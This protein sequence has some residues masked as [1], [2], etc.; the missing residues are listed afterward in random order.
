MTFYARGVKLAILPRSAA[1]SA[2]L[3]LAQLPFV[4][5]RLR[6]FLRTNSCVSA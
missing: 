4:L 5:S 6:P 2:L 3:S 1:P